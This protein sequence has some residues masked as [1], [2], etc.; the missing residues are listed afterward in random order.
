LLA[1]LA[2]SRGLD[3]AYLLFMGATGAL[4]AVMLD[5]VD[6]SEALKNRFDHR[7]RQKQI[8]AYSKKTGAA[9][10]DPQFVSAVV[11]EVPG[12]AADVDSVLKRGKQLNDIVQHAIASSPVS[13]QGMDYAGG[14]SADL[15]NLLERVK[16]SP[17]QQ[18]TTKP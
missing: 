4:G 13:V 2:A 8:S 14:L 17:A 6:L 5:V 7:R 1:K 10:V 16:A 18:P 11:A 9:S 12:G 15:L 3:L